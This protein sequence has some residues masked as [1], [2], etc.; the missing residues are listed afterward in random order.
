MV[1]KERDRDWAMLAGPY[2]A[3]APAFVNSLLNVDN[4]LSV[5]FG[6]YDSRQRCRR[7]ERARGKS[8]GPGSSRT[9]RAEQL[10]EVHVDI[11]E[12]QVGHN[13][14]S[15]WWTDSQRLMHTLCHWVDRSPKQ[16]KVG[17]CLPVRYSG[18][19]ALME[20]CLRILRN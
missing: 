11:S 5:K 9:S 15:G 2:P 14:E 18:C 13:S 4:N 3:T 7:E 8:L 12:Q 6:S 1:S 17:A 19:Y 10:L 16:R 20:L